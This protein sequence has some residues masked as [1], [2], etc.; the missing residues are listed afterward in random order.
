M[1]YENM[2]DM[3]KSLAQKNC[4]LREELEIVQEAV[5]R[6]SRYYLDSDNPN[7][8]KYQAMILNE[9]IMEAVCVANHERLKELHKDAE[10]YTGTSP[11]PE[12]KSR[13]Y[14]I[15]FAFDAF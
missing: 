8:R 1:S 7:H 11:L 10:R 12:E 2:S 4:A 14:N 6:Q 13:R 15:C 3:V 9:L 5:R